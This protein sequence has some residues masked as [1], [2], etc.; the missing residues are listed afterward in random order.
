VHYVLPRPKHL[1]IGL[2]G[3]HESHE[4]VNLD[5]DGKRVLEQS[6]C[7][8][9]S[10]EVAS[11][12]EPSAQIVG[13]VREE[14]VVEIFAGVIRM[15]ALVVIH[16]WS[17]RIGVVFPP[18]IGTS[19]CGLANV[20]PCALAYELARVQHDDVP[21]HVVEIFVEGEHSFSTALVKVGVLLYDSDDFVGSNFFP[22]GNMTEEAAEHGRVGE[23]EVVVPSCDERVLCVDGEPVRRLEER[24]GSIDAVEERDII[25]VEEMLGVLE[26]RKRRILFHGD[27]ESLGHVKHVLLLC[28]VVPVF[29]T[30]VLKPELCHKLEEE[31]G[32]YDPGQQNTRSG[33]VDLHFQN[34]YQNE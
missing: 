33:V 8:I 28:F 30:P 34:E 10:D 31:P 6:L 4:S 20:L 3:V 32:A 9:E 11:C 7:A 29:D 14:D 21:G 26:K 18:L 1:E 16:G 19:D 24:L 13:W 22:N 12:A 2:E 15:H 27:D 23:L 5:L 25:N 17:K